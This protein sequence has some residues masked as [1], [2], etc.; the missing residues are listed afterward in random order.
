[1]TKA[2]VSVF[3]KAFNCIDQS[4]RRTEVFADFCELTYC[5]LAK[6]ACPDAAKRDALEAQYMAVVKRYRNKDDV[7][8]MPELL[9]IAIAEISAGGCDF[10]G[11]VAG[12]IG[13]LDA[14]LG[15]F[16]TPYEVSRLM[17]NVSLTGVEEIIEKRGFY[18]VQEPAAGAGGMLLAMA[19]VIEEKGFDLETSVWFEAV[20]L[21]RPTFHMGYIQTAAR[22][23]AGRFVCGNSL[24]LEVFD[25]TYT[26]A[27]GR[28]FAKHG[29][30]WKRQKAER[31]ASMALAAQRETQEAEQRKVR[32]TELAAAEP[33]SKGVQ[34][35]LFD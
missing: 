25:L 31:A 8:R 32:L 19:D 35:S 17:A 1:M 21:S 5:A 13:A 7:R 34:L 11:A 27:A 20:E 18:T 14:R 23:L 30:P 26:A 12:E 29:D 24:S 6:R 4:K 9:A 28:F 2:A 3:V 22:G 16:F 33:I 15:Q 10:L